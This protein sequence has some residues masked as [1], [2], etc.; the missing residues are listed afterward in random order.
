MLFSL[1]HSLSGNLS[2]ILP[3]ELIAPPAPIT[4]WVPLMLTH[5]SIK[6]NS[7]ACPSLA[8]APWMDFGW[9]PLHVQPVDQCSSSHHAM[10]KPEFTNPYIQKLRAIKS[11]LMAA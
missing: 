1:V 8:V 6:Q 2:F 11:Q 3:G 5:F 9:F 10:R 7:T 4:L